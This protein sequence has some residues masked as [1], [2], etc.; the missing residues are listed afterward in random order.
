MDSSTDT[1]QNRSKQSTAS[2]TTKETQ[3]TA[4]A[5]NSTA[6]STCS[7]VRNHEKQKKTHD[8]NLKK[9]E[10][11]KMSD[12]TRKIHDE[13]TGSVDIPAPTVSPQSEQIMKD[14]WKEKED[15]KN[16][17]VQT[18]PQQKHDSS[19]V[20]EISKKSNHDL[21]PYNVQMRQVTDDN[22]ITKNTSTISKVE[23]K[24]EKSNEKDPKKDS[25]SE[26]K[27]QTDK[28]ISTEKQIHELLLH[29][30]LLLNVIRQCRMACTER[31]K[32]K[33][34]NKNDEVEEFRKITRI[35]L[36]AIKRP[37]GQEKSISTIQQRGAISLRKGASVGKKMA[38]AV[39]T[40]N[41][42]GGW[43]SDSSSSTG[44]SQVQSAVYSNG[45]S[46]PTPTKDNLATSGKRDN[47][48][49]MS[50]K[51]GKLPLQTAINIKNNKLE[52]KIPS[53]PPTACLGVTNK[54]SRKD[55]M[56]QQ[57][58]LPTISSSKSITSVTSK[59][60]ES[61]SSMQ[62]NKVS[63][64][65]QPT[66]KIKRANSFKNAPYYSNLGNSSVESI[67]SSN[68]HSVPLHLSQ[69]GGK[70]FSN[71]LIP[72]NKMRTE[73][74]KQENEELKIYHSEVNKL[75]K[76]RKSLQTEITARY[77]KRR[78]IDRKKGKNQPQLQ[79]PRKK[80]LGKNSSQI[81]QTA[82]ERKQLN[83]FPNELYRHEQKPLPCRRKTHW[84]YVLEEMRW[85]A[86]DFIEE[87]KWKAANG[88]SMASAVQSYFRE[89]ITSPGRSPLKLCH[90]KRSVDQEDIPQK[91]EEN[92]E[93]SEKEEKNEQ[94]K[95]S[96]DSLPI[97][98]NDSSLKEMQPRMYNEP[99]VEEVQSARDI[100]KL[101]NLMVLTHLKSISNTRILGHS[102]SPN[103]ELLCRAQQHF[104]RV[105]ERL[106]ISS[107]KTDKKLFESNTNGK[108]DASNLPSNDIESKPMAGTEV[109]DDK[110][111][112]NHSHGVN[113]Q[114][115]EL[116]HDEI[117]SRLGKIA[118]KMDKLRK[119]IKMVD[120]D[121]SE[122]SNKHEV[123]GSITLK[124]C[125]N[126][127]IK[128]FENLWESDGNTVPVTSGAILS[129][130]FGSGKTV[131]VGALLWK[132]RSLGSQILL[133]PSASFVSS[134]IFQLLMSYQSTSN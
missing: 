41:N 80:H 120:D 22:N 72:S 110:K 67:Y 3:K 38:A 56:T 116:S 87:R 100:S 40:L 59:M 29:R 17:S 127:S 20:N 125:Q 83:S 129:G 10:Y 85:L 91:N 123:M 48:I 4:G 49:S 43:I 69:S 51:S 44:P 115:E 11:N 97:S 6:A 118:S 16:N 39:S 21:R 8:G 33:G 24:N 45:S 78:I 2:S 106:G 65:T 134:K 99:T 132:R 98:Y 42:S 36:Q 34:S 50:N 104:S 130:P 92:D 109:N 89:K 58:T 5:K 102:D 7:A 37:Q 32:Q 46:S 95:N 66:Q 27:T 121:K 93:I 111:P 133:C 54:K 81:I 101:M 23:Q 55:S 73:E 18:T 105:K 74:Q 124:H 113:I 35:A 114:T 71:P 31:I 53:N 57:N 107:I 90:E 128:F 119:E 26:P 122:D 1:S 25:G 60:K 52:P 88:R 82:I 63:S 62:P 14:T 79:K 112:S 103:D 47:S 12:E 117:T 9:N 108:N 64:T 86:T 70:P 94:K 131:S 84:D 96:L 77:Q 13:S 30:H 28:S 15:N 19:T 61:S 126:L 76:K 75:L 68:T